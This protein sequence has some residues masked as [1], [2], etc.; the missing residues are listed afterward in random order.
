MNR[1]PVRD[2]G[3]R[4][5]DILERRVNVLTGLVAFQLLLLIVLVA[6]QVLP[7]VG[8]FDGAGVRPPADASEQMAEEQVDPEDVNPVV[9]TPERGT[10]PPEVPSNRPVRIEILNGCGVPK[11]AAQYADMLRAEGYDVRDTRNADRLNYEHTRIYDRAG[12]A[13]QATRLAH[14]LGV[15]GDRVYD[16]PN[17]NLVDVEL[18]LI[19]GNDYKNL[20]LH[21]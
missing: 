6:L 21:P 18:T 14:L 19:L 1:V 7:R 12:L 16:R 5:V 13:G 4:Q 2:S 10:L 17:P 9:E 8:L 20:K 11:L 15:P 3:R